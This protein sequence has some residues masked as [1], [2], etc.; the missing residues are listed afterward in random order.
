MARETGSALAVK[1]LLQHANIQT[2]MGY[3]HDA[4]DVIQQKI[5]PLRL[6]GE[7]YANMHGGD[8]TIKAE[9]LQLTEGK[10]SGECTALAPVN[11]EAVVEDRVDMLAGDMF[12]EIPE[13][14]AVRSLLKYEDLM[15]IRKVFV[16]YAS[17]NHSNND[18]ARARELLKRMVRK[19]GSEFY[20]KRRHVDGIL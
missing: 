2:S 9:Q 1:A 8:G 10:A 7:Q 16:W 11:G 15:L 13:G 18:V 19:G 5:S 4:E 17:Y 20:Q 3:I 6:L 12:P 14:I